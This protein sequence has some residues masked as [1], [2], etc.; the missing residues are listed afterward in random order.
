MVGIRVRTLIYVL[1][2]FEQDQRGVAFVEHGFAMSL[3]VS[4]V[5]GLSYVGLLFYQME[6]MNRAT[7][8][9]ATLAAEASGTFAAS[10]RAALIATFEKISGV[11]RGGDYGLHV[12]SLAVSN[13]DG[14][15]G[16]GASFVT[17]DQFT[18]GAMAGTLTCG[19]DS[20]D[21]DLFPDGERFVVAAAR[22]DV[23]LEGVV[24]GGMTTHRFIRA[25]AP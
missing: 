12:C 6:E 9:V 3:L 19:V 20:V 21:A 13:P 23:H 25:R 10:D 14:P 8:N 2:R 15:G 17:T 22:V 16:G 7:S 1:S 11:S 4:I 18:S 5:I 24:P